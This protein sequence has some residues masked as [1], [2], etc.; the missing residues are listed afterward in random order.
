MNI[1]Q[2]LVVVFFYTP[3]VFVAFSFLAMLFAAYSK[4][5][6][7]AWVSLGLQVASSLFTLAGIVLFVVLYQSYFG[8]KDMTVLFC[9]CVG[10]QMQL[11][12]TSALTY[13]SGRKSSDWELNVPVSAKPQDPERK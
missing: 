9:G 6:A 10:V 2:T 13:M 1:L 12:V 5:R 4:D 8:L 7:A 11:V 3:V